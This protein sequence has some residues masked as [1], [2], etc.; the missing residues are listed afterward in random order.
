[1]NSAKTRKR[2]ALA[3]GSRLPFDEN[4]SLSCSSPWPGTIPGIAIN[5][6]EATCDVGH[7]RTMR[8][9]TGMNGVVPVASDN[10]DRSSDGRDVIFPGASQDELRQ[11][12]EQ[13]ATPPVIR[14][15]APPRAIFA[16]RP[17]GQ[18][19]ATPAA[20][21]TRYTVA[22]CGFTPKRPARQLHSA[23]MTSPA[24]HRALQAVRQ[25]AGGIPEDSRSFRRCRR[26]PS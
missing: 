12:R 16:Q 3:N 4:T 19:R 23:V 24:S 9:A 22:F 6:A 21:H 26:A 8:Q 11:S 13:R 10:S 14:A 15:S 25:P 18:V 20:T 5:A 2:S 7:L 17:G 1:M